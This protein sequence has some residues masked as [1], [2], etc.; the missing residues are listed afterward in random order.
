MLLPVLALVLSADPAPAVHVEPLQ[1]ETF[2]LT[3]P[4]HFKKPDAKARVQY[5][6]EYWRTAYNVAYVWVGERAWIEGQVLGVA[7][8]AFIDVMDDKVAGEA[9]DPGGLRGA[10]AKNYI[11]KKL[12]KYLHPT[13]EEN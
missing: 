7:F 8:H 9:I 6:L 4:H 1:G 13:Y 11:V 2:A 10:M 5:M 12:K 3:Q